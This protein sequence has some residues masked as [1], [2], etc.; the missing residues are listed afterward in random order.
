[1]DA[2]RTVPVVSPAMAE[3]NPFI[4]PSNDLVPQSEPDS[5]SLE[6]EPLDLDQILANAAKSPVACHGVRQIQTAG[7]RECYDEEL[8][9]E[10]YHNTCCSTGLVQETLSAL[11]AVAQMEAL[12]TD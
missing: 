5:R 2:P 7:C 9:R 4:A 6:P 1:M 3:E 8:D 11:N 12:L 10:V